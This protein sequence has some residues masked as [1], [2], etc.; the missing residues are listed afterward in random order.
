MSRS[1]LARLQALEGA[2]AARAARPEGLTQP[3]ADAMVE[4]GKRL[5]FSLPDHL[6]RELEADRVRSVGRLIEGLWELGGNIGHSRAETALRA[7]CVAFRGVNLWQGGSEAALDCE[8][9]RVLAELGV[10]A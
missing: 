10:D 6:R 3:G 1:K 5:L 8:V 9:Q 4:L 7:Y 2:L